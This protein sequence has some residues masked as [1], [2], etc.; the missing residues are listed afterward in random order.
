MPRWQGRR[1]KWVDPVRDAEANLMLRR[2]GL[3]SSTTIA[4][5]QG[6][7]FADELAK[8]AID[9]AAAQKLKV[10]IDNGGGAPPPPTS[11]TNSL[12]AAN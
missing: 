6:L 11:P 8:I 10:A 1:W 5:E 2:A 9:E 12:G 4:D 3:K 7:E